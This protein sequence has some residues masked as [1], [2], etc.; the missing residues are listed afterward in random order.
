M[1]RRPMR[2]ELA[3]QIEQAEQQQAAHRA[4]GCKQ[5]H[6]RPERCDSSGH[7][8]NLKGRTCSV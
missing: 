1:E 6:K 7:K 8:E 2:D 5:P 3:E 4:E